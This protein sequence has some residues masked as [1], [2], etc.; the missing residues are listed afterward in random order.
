V[1]ANADMALDAEGRRRR[2]RGEAG[3]QDGE[4][5]GHSEEEARATDRG[6]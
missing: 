5:T 3:R 6:G 2:R 1:E 4:G